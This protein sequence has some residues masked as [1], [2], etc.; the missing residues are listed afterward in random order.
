MK[1]KVNKSEIQVRGRNGRDEGLNLFMKEELAD[2][3]CGGS[4]FLIMSSMKSKLSVTLQ[5]ILGLASVQFVAP[6]ETIPTWRLVD[7]S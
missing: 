7:T 2:V 3:D 1:S 5:R 4:V 6:Y